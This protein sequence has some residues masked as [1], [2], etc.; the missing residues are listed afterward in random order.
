MKRKH[1]VGLIL[2]FAFTIFILIGFSL[3]AYNDLSLFSKNNVMIWIVIFFLIVSFLKAILYVYEQIEKTKDF[4]NTRKPKFILIS[5]FYNVFDNHPFLTSFIVILFCWL[6][7][8]IAFYPA[9]LSPD[10]SYQILQYFGIDNKYS[11]Y[12]V[13]LDKNMLIT[14]HH[15]VFHTV[16]LGSFIK[17][18]L[19]LGNFNLGLFFYSLVQIM[20]LNM[21]L[22][23]TITFMKQIGMNKKFLIGCL[24]IYSL[25]PVFP[26]YAMSPVKDVLFTCFLI[27]YLIFIYQYVIL[28]RKVSFLK[29]LMILIM[30][31]L[32]RN[33]GIHI[34][35]FSLPLL[36]F[37]KQK[38]KLKIIGLL[39]A[40]P[41]FYFSYQ[42][43]LLPFFKITPGSVRE[44]LSVPFQQTARYVTYYENDISKKEQK[45]IDKVLDYSTL[46]E[47]Y[48]PQKADPVKN[49]FNRFAT[50]QDLKEYFKVWVQQGIK[51]PNVYIESFLSNTSGYFSPLKT[52]WYIYNSYHKYHNVLEE[53]HLY[54]SYNSFRPLRIILSTIGVIFPYIPVIGLCVN[55]GF[56]TWIILFMISYLFYKKKYQ[57]L[58]LFLP[59][60]L[61]LA[62]CLLSP[63]NTYFRY[64]MPNIFG[65]PLLIALFLSIVKRQTS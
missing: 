40:L 26:F 10:P 7:Y 34:I 17:I 37:I 3:D 16:L 11:Y 42:K 15:P 6:I 31:T 32:F 39:L 25:V 60:V 58:L 21:T 33:N 55:I 2:A 49:K 62:F 20:I 4:K 47:R 64:A 53:H 38:E 22:S 24:I 46:K 30:I 12:S 36:L 14:N 41:S 57:A 50:K 63:V 56:S 13:L 27:F 45:I 52:N 8:I 19:L 59:S 44:M 51:H 23:Y 35:I 65:M 28:K 5:K 1:W 61:V 43:I 54:Y 18:G 48:N 9:I 29:T